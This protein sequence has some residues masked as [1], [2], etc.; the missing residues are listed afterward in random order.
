[1]RLVVDRGR[2]YRDDFATRVAQRG[3]RA[4]EDAAGV[5]AER[6]VDPLRG[7]G[8]RVSIDDSRRA[9]VVA[10][11]RVA[12]RQ[13]VLVG[14]AGGVA[15]QAEAADPTRGPPVVLLLQPGVGD[16]Q[17]TAVEDVVRDE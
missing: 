11:P 7:Q 4:A 1:G 15:V 17:L 6:V 13:A 10:G 8:R 2:R 3:Q 9:P 12:H 16:D 5:D 14:L